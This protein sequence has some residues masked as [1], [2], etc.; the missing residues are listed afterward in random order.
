MPVPTNRV[1]ASEASTRTI[2]RRVQQVRT[3]RDHL[4]VGLEQ[5]LRALPMGERQ[6]LLKEVALPIQ[7]PPD[8]C[9][10]MKANLSI[11]WNKLRTLRR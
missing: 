10:A 11:S 5:E 7:I 4:G 1:D 2:Q 3:L 8:H 9:L 6:E